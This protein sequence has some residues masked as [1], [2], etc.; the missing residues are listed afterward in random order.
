MGITANSGP[1]LSYGITTTTSGQVTEYNEERAPSVTDLGNAL[2]DPRP[3]YNYSPGNAVGTAVLGLWGNQGLVDAI[4]SAQGS[5][6][7]YVPG[8]IVSC[9]TGSTA[10][11]TTLTLNT[12]VSSADGVTLAPTVWAPEQ[13]AYTTAAMGVDIGDDGQWL[14]FGSGATIAVWNPAD[15]VARAIAITGSSSGADDSNVTAT[16]EGRDLYGYQMTETITLGSSSLNG[17]IGS[18]A[19]KYVD[20]ITLANSTQLV[21]SHINI[22]FADKFGFPTI[23]NTPAYVEIMVVSSNSSTVTTYTASQGVSFASTATPTAT[24]SDVRGTW[25]STGGSV[26]FTGNNRLQIRTRLNPA[27]VNAVSASDYAGI[28]GSSQYY[29]G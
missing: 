25:T 27:N 8:T 9:L 11:T 18:K 22:A 13:G 17:A 3:T 28:F 19:F 20:S 24:T 6:V 29:D 5:S 10:G 2:L 1:F 21:S 26:N 7:N 15:A 4:P 14:T 16:V 23:V 12:S